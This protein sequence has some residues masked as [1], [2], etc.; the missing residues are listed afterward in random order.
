MVCIC[1][2]DTVTN[3]LSSFPT[4]G[5]PDVCFPPHIR[6]DTASAAEAEEEEIAGQLDR[7]DITVE[8]VQGRFAFPT[9][10]P[11]PRCE[12]GPRRVIHSVKGEFH[13]P[14]IWKGSCD[15]LPGCQDPPC[16]PRRQV[17]RS[18]CVRVFKWIDGK[19]IRIGF[20]IRRFLDHQSCECKQCRHIRTQKECVDTYPCPNSK[21]V[22]SFCYWISNPFPV[23][24]GKRQVAEAAPDE[25]SLVLF[26]FGRCDCC[27][28][29]CCPAPQRFN[30]DRCRCECPNR[31][32]CP[33]G[34]I[35]NEITC[36]CE[37]PKGSK[38]NAN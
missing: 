17:W 18:V 37:C 19:W 2:I 12:D 1:R 8:A 21:N 4:T 29:K 3:S 38:M 22:C 31:I 25:L 36:K 24:I 7:G 26:P 11:I 27:T 13:W 20:R 5:P 9:I 23:P 33:P 32:R 35:F 6:L 14:P 30:Y 16:F 34:L 15:N 10:S 28:P